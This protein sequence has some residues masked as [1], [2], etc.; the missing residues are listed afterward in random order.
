MKKSLKTAALVIA[1]T[2]ALFALH[3]MGS[4]VGDVLARAKWSII[5][6]AVAGLTMYQ[7]LNASI[8]KD[9]FAGLGLKVSRCATARVWIE[10]ESM[11]WLPGGIWGY[12]SRVVN[13]RKLGA[14]I[15]PAS[16][17]LAIELSLTVLAWGAVALCILPTAIGHDLQSRALAWVSNSAQV[18]WLAVGATTLA[19]FTLLAFLLTIPRVKATLGSILRR[20]VPS[21]AGMKLQPR[22]LVRAWTS[23]L[24][25]CLF[26]GT[27]L[28]L[29][30]LA[31]PGLNVPWAAVIG[32]GGVA[33]LVGFFAIGIPGGIGVREAALAGLLVW[34]GPMEA[35]VAAAV[36]F[37]VAQVVAELIALA[38]SLIVSWKNAR[39]TLAECGYT[40][41]S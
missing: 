2:I 35:A 9:V 39:N 6:L 28:W 23:Y 24:G 32:I 8:W 10:S 26:N 30:T 3:K 37:R 17:A 14:D 16:A 34:Y 27:L 31:I 19:A 1:V 12:G 22:S 11:K 21:V 25:L 18:T 29:I 36:L 40:V 15:R 5:A 41:L 33:W 38:S 20:F 7:F 4:Q 13:A